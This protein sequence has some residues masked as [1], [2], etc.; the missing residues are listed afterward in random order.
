MGSDHPKD[1]PEPGPAN[2]KAPAEWRGY[3]GDD[4][5]RQIRD[6]ALEANLVTHDKLDALL[7]P[8]PLEVV[9][10]LDDHKAPPRT[11]LRT[12]LRQLNKVRR[13]RGGEV[14]IAVFLRS[15]IDDTPDA[16]ACAILEALLAKVERCEPPPPRGVDANLPPQS[17]APT[18]ARSSAAIVI[19]AGS[20]FRHA[21]TVM[22]KIDK[23]SL[24]LSGFSPEELR[25]KIRRVDIIV[26]N[27]TE[28]LLALRDYAP[29]GAIRRYS[30]KTDGARLVL[31]V[32]ETP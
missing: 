7:Q 12:Q 29:D 32:E 13:L 21:A 11:R 31:T 8:V 25:V 30:V 22:A 2:A 17:T 1:R 5:L 27:A 16:A 23:K 14:P 24:A 6:L 10:L 9:A 15:L 18:S 28:A 19:P 3:L 26:A 4:D 20:T